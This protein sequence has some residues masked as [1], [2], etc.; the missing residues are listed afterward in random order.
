MD[1]SET[2]VSRKNL[3]VVFFTTFLYRLLFQLVNGFPLRADFFQRTAVMKDIAAGRPY[4]QYLNPELFYQLGSLVYYLPV[5][6]IW[7]FS[8]ATV[9]IAALGITTVYY[10]TSE[11]FGAREGLY[12]AFA[13]VVMSVA[14]FRSI[15]G[16][17]I[18]SYISAYIFLPLFLLTLFRW[19]QDNDPT[20]LL[21]GSVALLLVGGF[22]HLVFLEIVTLIG[23]AFILVDRRVVLYVPALLLNI[24][25]MWESYGHYLFERTVS[26]VTSMVE[27]FQTFIPVAEESPS[28][29][30]GGS[31]TS[32]KPDGDG[33]E[34]IKQFSDSSLLNVLSLLSMLNP[35]VILTS[36][37]GFA[38]DNNRSREEVN[39]AFRILLAWV[40]A[41]LWMILF[42]HFIQPQ[43]TGRTIR[44]LYIPF[45]M[46]FGVGVEVVLSGVKR[47]LRSVNL[48]PYMN[49]RGVLLAI[50]VVL[51]GP[52]LV[53]Q[54]VP[55]G[56]AG[57][58]VHADSE[59]TN[60]L[61]KVD[62]EGK[63]LAPP[64]TNEVVNYYH[65]GTV[66][67]TYPRDFTI[68][69]GARKT[70]AKVWAWWENPSQ[71]ER[72]QELGVDWVFV[73]KRDYFDQYWN[74]PKNV[75]IPQHFDQP[76]LEIE[77]ENSQMALYEVKSCR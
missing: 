25:L 72:I 64:L 75:R 63:I 68:P 16:W 43:A 10:V 26:L 58:V 52:M 45:A 20:H 53:Y 35:F 40:L 1:M 7:F 19:K 11:F 76:Y 30:S 44:H 5:D 38:S 48:P 14:P 49:V 32:S 9:F 46:T 34:P 21:T 27:R 42:T 33:V 51:S 56:G 24:G 39:I 71:C 69:S 8:I 29:P 57:Y 60:G 77:Y 67:R 61:E 73:D 65:D 13:L 22:H 15:Y 41:Q 12:A 37:I 18:N 54:V 4:A 6:P 66:W 47:G 2:G 36:C 50:A 28:A 74:N 62:V 3:V 70:Q 59:L 31:E 23:F 17:Q 55:F